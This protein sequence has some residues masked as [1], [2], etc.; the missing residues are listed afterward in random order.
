[1][2]PK[3]ALPSTSPQARTSH[4]ALPFF[5]FLLSISALINNIDRGSLSVAAPL[6]KGE[7]RIS[8]AQLGVLLSA[9]FW[10]YTA[11]M[12]PSGWLADRF[13]ANWVLAGGFIIW[14]LAMSAT[15]LVH[16]FAA[17]IVVRLLLGAGESVTF[18]SYG[19]ILARHVR[20]EHR[21]TANAMILS[22]WLSDRRSARICAAS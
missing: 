13:D 10:T 8:A 1:M 7:L 3:A 11:L 18:P 22:G 15:G 19:R 12:Y 14:S 4:T 20:Q 6:I 5:L 17:L 21:G 2:T 16:G 9:F